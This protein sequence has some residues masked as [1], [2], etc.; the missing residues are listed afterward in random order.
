LSVLE[1]YSSWQSV[2]LLPLSD[3]GPQTDL[4]QVRSIKGL[5][6]VKANISTSP[7]GSIDGEAFSGAEVPKRNIVLTLG[8]NP[9]WL[10]YSMESLRRLLYL[11]FMP[12]QFVR[13]VF[14]S[15]DDFPPVEISGYV[16]TVDPNIFSKDVEVQV[17][18]ICP[19]PYFTAVE[20]TVIAG[21]SDQAAR[22]VQYEGS[23]EVGVNA[24]LTF[25]S[26]A[27]PTLITMQIG[28]VSNQLQVAATVT[29]TKYFVMN[30]LPSQKYVQNVEMGSGLITNLLS[31]VSDGSQWPSLRPGGNRV[32]ITSNA[33]V[34]DWQ[35]TYFARFGGL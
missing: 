6:P 11:Y 20:P 28:D 35:L 27:A 25:L 9:D 31:K 1:A 16:E 5:E 30:S 10:E 26:G 8:L 34:Q 3:G 33:G 32:Y 21:V 22:T 12:K 18:I 14:R 7:Y 13:L 15:D 24:K 4:I 19:D 17:S 29:A 23:V 2:P